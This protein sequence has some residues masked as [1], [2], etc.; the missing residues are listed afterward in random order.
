MLQPVTPFVTFCNAQLPVQIQQGVGV[1]MTV[2]VLY[3]HIVLFNV[4]ITP[5]VCRCYGN[6][7]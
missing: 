5:Y 4:M 3:L 6:T 2:S 1:K 7:H